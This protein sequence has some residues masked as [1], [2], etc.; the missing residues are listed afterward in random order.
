MDGSLWHLIRL[1]YSIGTTPDHRRMLGKKWPLLGLVIAF[2]SFVDFTCDILRLE[3]WRAF[4]IMALIISSLNTIILLPIWVYKLGK[5]LP[6]GMPHY[7]DD[8]SDA[9]YT[10]Q[11]VLSAPMAPPSSFCPP[12]PNWL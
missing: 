11:T 9:F 1:F 10:T 3:E 12:F 4:T 2:L 5:I 6:G 8:A 7:S